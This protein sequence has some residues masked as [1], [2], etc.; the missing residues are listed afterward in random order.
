M[1]YKVVKES[2][3]NTNFI[4]SEEI[5]LQEAEGDG[6]WAKIK[7]FFINIINAIKNFFAKLFGKGKA[8]T[9][10][11]I[12]WMEQNEEKI[13]SGFVA[14]NSASA[15]LYFQ[16]DSCDFALI[17]QEVNDIFNIVTE[18][19]QHADI[20]EFLDDLKLLD[21]SEVT[22]DV[23]SSG[24]TYL[25]Q[26]KKEFEE[27]NN[28]ARS[29]KNKFVFDNEQEK[30]LIDPNLLKTY[31]QSKIKCDEEVAKLK[32]EIESQFNKTLKELDQAAAKS[33]ADSGL[34]KQALSLAQQYA[35]LYQNFVIGNIN[36]VY[37]QISKAESEIMKIAKHYA[38][39]SGK[40][41]EDIKD[42][43]KKIIIGTTSANEAYIDIGGYG[44]FSDTVFI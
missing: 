3:N 35:T 20:S 24:K 43:E 12:K 2:N 23:I 4:E 14:L 30:N 18:V 7:N 9:E 33:T 8:Q 32:S 34:V 44:I 1:I 11:N 17:W 39:Y 40:K 6:I 16:K 36:R 13:K 31:L 38:S 37:G 22:E 28:Q 21:P 19:N 42:E 27:K 41:P 29:I 5:Y 26:Q 15:K 10:N 25:E